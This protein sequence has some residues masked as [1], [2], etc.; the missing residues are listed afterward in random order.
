MMNF[1]ENEPNP[2]HYKPN[3]FTLTIVPL[4]ISHAEQLCEWTYEAPY[5]RFNWPS[6]EQMQKDEIEFGDPVLRAEQY[7]AILDERH[8][9]IG[10][11]QF[12]PMGSVTR[13]GLG[14]RPDLCSKGL[15]P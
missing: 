14:L 5:E 15:G 10:Y 1:A 9:L 4:E 12:F 13:I 3:P 8:V 7:G 2:T 11:A 6:W